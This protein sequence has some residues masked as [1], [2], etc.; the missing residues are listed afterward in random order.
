MTYQHT[1]MA[2]YADGITSTEKLVLIAYAEHADHH[3]YCWP[4]AQRLADIT[5]LSR[6]TVTR[7]NASLRNKGLIKSVRRV[8][9]KTNEPISNLTRINVSLLDSMRRRDVE[10]YADLIHEITFPEDDH[11]DGQE[12]GS[13]QLI[14]HGEPYLRLTVSHTQ[15]HHEPQT[16]QRNNQ[17]TSSS[18]PLTD[19]RQSQPSH[20]EEEATPKSETQERDDDRETPD[21][22]MCQSGT[23]V[24]QPRPGDHDGDGEHQAAAG[25][26]ASLPGTLNAGET[27]RLINLTVAAIA[28]GWTVEDLRAEL[29][30]DLGNAWS[31]VAVWH[32]RLKPGNLGE[33]PAAPARAALP[34]RCDHPD[35][36]QY[37]TDRL[38]YPA[39]GPARPCPTCHPMYLGDAR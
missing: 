31:R 15:A 7:A 11:E 39:N 14:H 12:T 2:L 30:R 28:A 20:E 1:N 5:G 18:S 23:T 17:R 4:S 38:L 26:V 21:L 24:P 35:H 32:D 6:A 25:L 19:A 16:N 13:D 27:R 33:P 34:P 3:G 9:P 10:R 37:G 22:L 29:V 8:N 36:D